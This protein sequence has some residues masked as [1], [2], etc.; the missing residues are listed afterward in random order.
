MKKILLRFAAI[1]LMLHSTCAFANVTTPASTIFDNAEAI[2]QTKSAMLGSITSKVIAE[3][4]E[5]RQYLLENIS[6]P[7]S[8]IRSTTFNLAYQMYHTSSMIETADDAWA[9]LFASNELI[10]KYNSVYG[11]ATNSNQQTLADIERMFKFLFDYVFANSDMSQTSAL[12]EDFTLYK[13]LD[14]YYK[15]INSCSSNAA[16][17]AKLQKLYC[18]EFAAW[19][20][21]ER[22]KIPYLIKEYHVPAMSASGMFGSMSWVFTSSIRLNSL[23]NR[24]DLLKAER[25]ILNGGYATIAKK[26]INKDCSRSNYFKAIDFLKTLT[27]ESLSKAIVPDELFANAINDIKY[28]EISHKMIEYEASLTDWVKIREEIT[29]LLPSASQARYKEAT[30]QLFTY[31]YDS[32]IGV[33]KGLNFE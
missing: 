2:K 17:K 30:M 15:L 29:L 10:N 19:F 26:E 28:S 20:D 8:A 31:M 24:Q 13:T 6:K 27:K 7:L 9:W 23:T 22:C 3:A 25:T 21:I 33:Q 1:I 32:L 14:A 11:Y 4:N 12:Y 5:T 18:R 16:T